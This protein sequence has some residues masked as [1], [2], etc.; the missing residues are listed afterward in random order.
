[1]QE[2][3]FNEQ[4]IRKTFE[5]GDAKEKKFLQRLLGEDFFKPKDIM[6]RVKSFLDACH[7]TGEDPNDTK[8]TQGSAH[9]VAQEK[10][11]VICKALCDGVKLT[12]RDGNQRKWFPWMIW[13][14]ETSGFRF[15]GAFYGYST[16]NALLGSRL[17]VDTEAKAKYL[18]THPEFVTLIN[19]LLI[20]HENEKNNL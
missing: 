20:N 12:Y 7:E 15:D 10:L 14:E 11:E 13:H 3:K 9:R 16:S 8:F 1:M 6:D 19:Q 2:V 17:Q 5:Q 18:G 4:N